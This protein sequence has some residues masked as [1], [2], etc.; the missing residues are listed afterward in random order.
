MEGCCLEEAG[1]CGATLRHPHA[2]CTKGCGMG[3]RDR[4]GLMDWGLVLADTGDVWN[5]ARFEGRLAAA[6]HEKS[7]SRRARGSQASAPRVDSELQSR[8]KQ[9]QAPQRGFGPRCISDLQMHHGA[10][11]YLGKLVFPTP[12]ES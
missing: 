7:V 9:G 5:N 6:R 10:L 4:D 11:A 3:G 12:T 1:R 8:F 2:A